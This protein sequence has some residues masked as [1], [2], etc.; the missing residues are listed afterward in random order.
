MI[1]NIDDTLKEVRVYSYMLAFV[2]AVKV[3]F[4]SFLYRKNGSLS[5]FSVQIYGVTKM[6]HRFHVCL[7]LNTLVLSNV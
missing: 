2:Y 3:Q 1:K 6:Q 4:V 5:Y 7:Y